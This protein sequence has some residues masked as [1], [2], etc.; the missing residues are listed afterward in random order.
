V[1]RAALA[2]GAFGFTVALLMAG[3]AA[4]KTCELGAM[5][6]ESQIVT[7][8]VQAILSNPAGTVAE[9]ESAALQL[10][11]QQVVCAVTALEAY[12]AKQAGPAEPTTISTKAALL[13][14]AADQQRWHAADIARQF[15][16]LHKGVSCDSRHVS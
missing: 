13:T 7:A 6:K 4:L 12:W 3:C 15:L 2:V 8:T 11:E 1:T 10:G 16:S 9:L 5:P 14:S